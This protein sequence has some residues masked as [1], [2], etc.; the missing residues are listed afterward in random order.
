MNKMDKRGRG[1]FVKSSA[2]GSLDAFFAFLYAQKI[3]I[4]GTAIGTI[5]KKTV[6]LYNLFTVRVESPSPRRRMYKFS[7]GFTK[8]L[9]ISRINPGG[10]RAAVRVHH[11]DG[12]HLLV[13]RGGQCVHV[14]DQLYATL[15]ESAFGLIDRCW[16]SCAWA[17]SASSCGAF[18]A[19]CS[20][21]GGGGWRQQVQTGRCRTRFRW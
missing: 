5:V 17:A 13:E 20:G 7:G 18:S 19:S 11:P 2:L 9:R 21:G 15:L 16:A 1:V 8:A 6:T 12:R 3:Y 10:V 4:S 14:V